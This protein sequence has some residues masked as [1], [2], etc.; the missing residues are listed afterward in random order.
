MGGITSEEL[1]ARLGFTQPSDLTTRQ[2]GAIDLMREKAFSFASCLVAHTDPSREQSEALTEI[3]HALAFAVKAIVRHPFVP[4]QALTDS[5]APE[6]A[7]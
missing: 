1:R 5:A 3:E 7:D 6:P 4:L 2:Q